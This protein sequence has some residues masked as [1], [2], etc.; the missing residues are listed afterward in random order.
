MKKKISFILLAAILLVITLKPISSYA[1]NGYR[2]DG[3]NYG[4]FDYRDLVPVYNKSKGYMIV[5]LGTEKEMYGKDLFVSK[6]YT[7]LNG[8][9]QMKY[10]GL[11]TFDFYIN[12]QKVQSIQYFNSMPP[13]IIKTIKTSNGE[14]YI[15][16]KVK[17]KL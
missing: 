1:Y 7:K 13:K 14:K 6:K 3:Q 15:Y 8:I 16:E 9:Y 4:T 12:G 17:V 5:T 2:L 10:Y 11:Y